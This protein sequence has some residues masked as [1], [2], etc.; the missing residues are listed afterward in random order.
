MGYYCTIN[1]YELSLISYTD[2]LISRVIKL[3]LSWIYSNNKKS[4]DK[5]KEEIEKILI[6]YPEIYT[7]FDSFSDET[8][9]KQLLAILHNAVKEI[10]KF[11]N[12]NGHT[13]SK[14]VNNH[15]CSEHKKY[16]KGKI[17]GNKFKEFKKLSED[18]VQN[19]YKVP[20]SLG[21]RYYYTSSNELN[22]LLEA[23]RTYYD[24]LKK[25]HKDL[26]IRFLKKSLLKKT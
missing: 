8:I 9:T 25:H 13:I 3:N 11:I 19:I 15:K 6:G 1:K 2:D 5:C 10:T 12:D 14:C 22:E 17:N 16:L 7:Y 18:L 24:L 4:V 23:L 20:Q 21:E 26:K